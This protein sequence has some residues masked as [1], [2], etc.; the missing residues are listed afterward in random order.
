MAGRARSQSMSA[1]TMNTK[2][3]VNTLQLAVG[4]A[5]AAD[6]RHRCAAQHSVQRTRKGAQ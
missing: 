4:F 6:G 3:Q 2:A 5:R 1:A